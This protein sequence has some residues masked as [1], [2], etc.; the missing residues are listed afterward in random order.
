MRGAGAGWQGQ[1]AVFNYGAWVGDQTYSW[2]VKRTS[3]AQAINVWTKYWP[4]AVGGYGAAPSGIHGELY[5]TVTVAAH[6][7]YPA[8]PTTGF[9][10]HKASETR[11]EGGWTSHEETWRPYSAIY[12]D[13][14]VDGTWKYSDNWVGYTTFWDSGA[15]AGH[16]YRYRTYTDGP[17]GSVGGY[18]QSNAV[19]MTALPPT[20]V[21]LSLTSPTRTRLGIIPACAGSS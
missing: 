20:D 4:A 15:S 18:D 14:C 3:H 7:Y 1:G 12:V 10:V 13:R 17:G 19:Y 16:W 2:W 21:E 9:A 6:P 8:K 11:I 5:Q